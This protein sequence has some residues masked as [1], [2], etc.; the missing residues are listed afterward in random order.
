MNRRSLLALFNFSSHP[1]TI[2]VPLRAHKLAPDIVYAAAQVIRGRIDAAL[3]A[4][5]LDTL[6]PGP[7]R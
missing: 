1:A 3:A 2:A 6:P 4:S 7:Q 5:R